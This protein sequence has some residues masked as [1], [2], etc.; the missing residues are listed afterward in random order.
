MTLTRSSSAIDLVFDQ[1]PPVEVIDEPI[2]NGAL[3]LDDVFLG[4]IFL[5]ACDRLKLLILRSGL[6]D[7]TRRGV[8]GVVASLVAVSA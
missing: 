5:L 2:Y 1:I 3:S 7:A 4:E 6:L 8:A